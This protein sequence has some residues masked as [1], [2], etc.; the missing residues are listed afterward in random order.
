MTKS[1]V[2]L[3]TS[4]AC[5]TSAIVLFGIFGFSENPSS[6]HTVYD[7]VRTEGYRIYTIPLP[8]K[9]DFAGE[10]VP[11]SQSD[12]RERLDREF[13]VNTYWHSNAFLW[14]K[15]AN[16]WFPVIEPILELNGVPKDFKYLCMVESS[17]IQDKSPRG[18]VGFWQFMEETAKQFGLEV[19]EEVDERYNVER[20]TEAACRYFKQ[21]YSKFGSWSMVAA[22][23]NMGMTGLED[24]VTR[25]RQSSYWDLILNDETSRY[26]CRIVAAKTIINNADTYG[27]VI[28]PIDLY[29]P[30]KYKNVTVDH[31]IDDFAS[32]AE[33]YNMTYK[34]FKLLNPWLRQA[35]LRNKPGRV[36]TFKVKE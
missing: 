19:N 27:F 34:E 14:M 36:Y 3:I 13:L 22:S 8:E 35:Y 10:E 29:E 9:L 12:V 6:K 31:S 16:R 18:A 23:Y 25:Q 33:G 4:L 15:R 7:R 11:L 26:V 24:Q 17:L 2:I 1:R 32:F 30:L 20:S 5:A 21:A 28:R